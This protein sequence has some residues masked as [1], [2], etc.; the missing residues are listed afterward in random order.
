[1]P[2]AGQTSLAF[3]GGMNISSI[4]IDHE[5][6]IVP[7]IQSATG[8]AL[9]LAFDFP[10]SEELGMRLVGRYSQKGG[11]FSI[12]QGAS[13]ID[14]S[15]NPAYLDIAALGRLRFPL[16]GNRLFLALVAGPVVGAEVSCGIDLRTTV[17][18]GRWFISS[19]TCEGNGMDWSSV[20]LGL[21]GGAGVEVR[22]TDRFVASSGVLYTYGLVDVDISSAGSVRHCALTLDI[23]LGYTFP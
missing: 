7:D 22:V 8:V 20:D 15:I 10:L 16:T 19:Q 14:A 2:A 11:Q 1:M 18:G 6:G 21:A 17:L 12:A 5:S 4:D 23:G 3:T 9:G 13:H